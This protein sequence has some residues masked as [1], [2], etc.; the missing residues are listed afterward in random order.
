MYQRVEWSDSNDEFQWR[1]AEADGGS[2]E[3]SDSGVSIASWGSGRPKLLDRVNELRATIPGGPVEPVEANEPVEAGEA[4]EVAEVGGV[5][6]V[7]G[8][9]SSA[10]GAG[11]AGSG[12]FSTASDSGA[13]EGVRGPKQRVRERR[14]RAGIEAGSV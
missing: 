10:K 6:G 3:R 4:T 5:G 7:A 13:D 14:W 2:G 1:T 11:S 9:G 8:S 12:T